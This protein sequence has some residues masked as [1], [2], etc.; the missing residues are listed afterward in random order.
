MVEAVQDAAQAV[1]DPLQSDFVRELVKHPYWR[2]SLASAP[3]AHRTRR[4][5]RP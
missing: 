2:A 4:R 3:R 1:G 5:R